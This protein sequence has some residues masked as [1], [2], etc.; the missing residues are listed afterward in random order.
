MK[1]KSRALKPSVII[2]QQDGSLGVDNV[3]NILSVVVTFFLDVIDVIQTRNYVRLLEIV[4]NLVRFGNII[5]VAKSAWLELQEMSLEESKAVVEH[6]KVV[7][8]LDNDELEKKIEDAIDIIPRIYELALKV[9]GIGAEAIDVWKE[10]KAIFS[11][12]GELAQAA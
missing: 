2:A 5:D 3:K 6:V 11:D 9:L 8:D 1:V 7:V 12:E 10:L 4:F